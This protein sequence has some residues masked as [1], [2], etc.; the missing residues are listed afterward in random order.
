MR[1]IKTDK[2]TEFHSLNNKICDVENFKSNFTFAY[3]V[4][5]FTF[6]FSLLFYFQKKIARNH[7]TAPKAVTSFFE[8]ES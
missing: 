8:E 4:K 3:N 6:F 1:L 5:Q 2:S 7:D